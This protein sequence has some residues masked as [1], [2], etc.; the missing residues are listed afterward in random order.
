[1][2]CFRSTG[3]FAMSKK[4]KFEAPTNDGGN[5]GQPLASEI[6]DKAGFAK[7]W[8][9]SKR[10]CDVWIAAGMPHCKCSK[11]AVRIVI[12]EADAWV[13]QQF[14]TRRMAQPQSQPKLQIES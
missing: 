11:R 7:R 8:G 14:S 4:S 10:T 5:T 13:R 6:T 2:L 3:N 12:A 9:F 1:M